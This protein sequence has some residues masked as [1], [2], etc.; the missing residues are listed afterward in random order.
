V[1]TTNKIR[2]LVNRTFIECCTKHTDV[3]FGLDRDALV[4]DSQ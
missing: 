4:G 1:S 3:P 2:L